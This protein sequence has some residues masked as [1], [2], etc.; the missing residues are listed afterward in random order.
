MR[1]RENFLNN[2]IRFGQL[3][4]FLVV[5]VVSVESWAGEL[6]VDQL[7]PYYKSLERAP[8]SYVPNQ[9][10]EIGPV[11]NVIWMDKI[12]VE[13]SAGVLVNM[14]DSL[15]SWES[16]DEYAQLWNM[17]STGLYETPDMEARKKFINQRLLKYVDKRI[18]GEIRHAKKGSAWAKVG[19]VQQALKPNTTVKMNKYFTLKIK[20][21]V[22]EGKVIF[23]IRN[24]FLQL[25]SYV[26]LNGKTKLHTGKNF[27][28]IRLQTSLDYHVNEGRWIA[29]VDKKITD[30]VGARYTA[31]KTG[32]F[33]PVD[34]NSN[35]VFQFYFNYPF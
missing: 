6:Q 27:K 25:N 29:S 9:E 11:E 13:D 14:R 18:S 33:N 10:V 24:P 4:L 26:K 31:E 23:T 5:T 32:F 28:S 19:E 2:C 35:Q 12:F 1:M 20:G 17:K 16:T 30:H 8:S 21:K 15:S 3:V 34:S 7:N 22:L